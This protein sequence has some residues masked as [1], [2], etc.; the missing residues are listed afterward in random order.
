MFQRRTC[1]CYAWKIGRFLD[2]RP[3]PLLRA[4]PNPR[5]P[6][7]PLALAGD[8]KAVKPDKAGAGSRGSVR[9]SR[10]SARDA[11]AL[12]VLDR[13]GASRPVGPAASW[14]LPLNV[15]PDLLAPP[16]APTPAELTPP[17]LLT[18]E[19][20]RSRRRLLVAAGAAPRGPDDATGALRLT[21]EADG[22]G[23]SDVRASWMVGEDVPNRRWAG[24]LR[25]MSAMAAEA[26]ALARRHRLEGGRQ[27]AS[28]RSLR[29]DQ[30][31]AVERLSRPA[32]RAARGDAGAVGAEQNAELRGSWAVGRSDVLRG[33]DVGQ[34]RFAG[35]LRSD[36]TPGAG[37]G[38]GGAMEDRYRRDAPPR[39]GLGPSTDDR[40]AMA[41]QGRRAARLRAAIALQ[42]LWRGHRARRTVQGMRDARLR[43]EREAAA[44]R[45]QAAVRG[46]RGRREADRRRE[47]RDRRRAHEAANERERR[48]G[49]EGRARRAAAAAALGGGA[50]GEGAAGPRAS[51]G[52]STSGAS[53]PPVLTRAQIMARPLRPAETPRAAA[54]GAPTAGRR[55]GSSVRVSGA[56][57]AAPDPAEAGVEADGPA[58]LTPPLARVSKAESLRGGFGSR[59]PKAADWAPPVAVAARPAGTGA[60]RFRA[61][62][63][64]VIATAR[65]AKAARAMAARRD[66]A[67]R[68]AERDDAPALGSPRGPGP[69]DA[70]A[71]P[72]SPDGGGGADPGGDGDDDD[73]LDEATMT[74]EA[75]EARRRAQE[76][77]WAE[78][79]AEAAEAAAE[80][81]VPAAAAGSAAGAPGAAGARTPDR[82]RE[83]ARAAREAAI[84]AAADAE[85]AALVA[86]AAEEAAVAAV[87]AAAGD[88]D[89]AAGA[90]RAAD[91]GGSCVGVGAPADPAG[92]APRKTD[93]GTL[94]AA[95]GGAA[96]GGRDPGAEPPLP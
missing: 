32:D 17:S 3:R 14:G 77:S 59:T 52:A 7:L 82:A 71:A 47:I 69:A 48:R 78:A 37:G 75:R 22:L 83:R 9:A 11:S 1:S 80:G 19:R 33:A 72:A 30:A 18:D 90:P 35:S 57:G 41:L 10:V 29:A 88:G 23:R 25:D 43:E 73:G 42:S 36:P 95:P 26:D 84:R 94:F 5:P 92:F 40:R 63:A 85:A 64:A 21:G 55:R 96:T 76:R 28:M 61:A 67:E 6:P 93:T 56:E 58:M 8:A 70:G 51:G 38:A 91:A 65:A 60:D 46:R 66:A 13:R 53:P 79:E 89:G 87:V 20:I 15:P 24:S 2:C 81:R 27:G 86:A 62:G 74:P 34:R 49:E 12:G 44:R 39:R 50:T 31:A 45:I 16:P 4:A 54:G 68:A